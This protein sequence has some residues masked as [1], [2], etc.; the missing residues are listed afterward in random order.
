MDG[1]SPGKRYDKRIFWKHGAGPNSLCY[2]RYMAT[3]ES[4]RSLRFAFRISHSYISVIIRETLS[5]ICKQLVPIFIPTLTKEA[6]T[7]KAEEFW[8]RWNFP[9]CIGALDG[10]HVRIFAPAKSGSLY[11]NYKEYFSLVMLALVDANCKFIALDVG[12]YGKEGDSSIFNKSAFGRKVMHC[13]DFFPADRILP[14][15]NKVLPH[16]II[17]DEAFRLDKHLMK[18]FTKLS[19]T[20]DKSKAIFNYRLSRARRVSENAFGLL[21]Q[22]FRVFYTPIAVKPE[23]CDDLI[24]AACCLHNL[25]REG[26]LEKKGVPYY[27]YDSNEE[28]SNVFRNF[29]R[30]GGYQNVEGFHVRD[31]FM[32]FFLQEGIVEWQNQQVSKV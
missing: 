8:E 3:G 29:T 13:Q 9:N 27:E 1:Q 31:E 11:F 21:S 32:R 23:V 4:F 17:G 15:S 18:P 25:L 6:L 2:F 19:A 30:A 28:N 22:V 20:S 24:I 10:K 14:R 12:S 16:V 5:A 7:K 26:Y